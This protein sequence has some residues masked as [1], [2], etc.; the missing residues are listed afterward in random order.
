[1]IYGA[2]TPGKI[3]PAILFPAHLLPDSDMSKTMIP[4]GLS[5]IRNKN[6]MSVTPWSP[7]NY[8]LD[9]N[10]EL[11]LETDMK[12]GHDSQTQ[13]EIVEAMEN[14]MEH[15]KGK[16]KKKKKSGKKSATKESEDDQEDNTGGII[17]EKGD[18]LDIKLKNTN[19][20][21]KNVPCDKRPNFSESS[22]KDVRKERDS[23]Y[24]KGNQLLKDRN[25]IQSNYKSLKDT[26]DGKLTQEQC[27]AQKSG[28][29]SGSESSSSSS[30]SAPVVTSSKTNDSAT[31]TTKVGGEGEMAKKKGGKKKKTSVSGIIFLVFF[32]LV[33]IAGMGA[34][35]YAYSNQTLTSIPVII[36]V[37]ISYIFHLITAI[38]FS[39][40]NVGTGRAGVILS[41]AGIA[42][43]IASVAILGS[44][45]KTMGVGAG[46]LIFL[47]G[48]ILI[49]VGLSKA[50]RKKDEKTLRD[51]HKAS[52]VSP[53][54]G[55]ICVIAILYNVF[56]E[57]E[58]RNNSYNN[59]NS[60]NNSNRN[61]NNSNN[62]SN[63]LVNNA[64]RLLR[65][66]G[67]ALQEEKPSV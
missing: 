2:P 60:N 46:A 11:H 59:N 10:G 19:M 38:Y 54:M 64:E 3:S 6:I 66:A 14:Y 62:V 31:S 67:K 41:G 36:L 27:N 26:C 29:G 63:R 18:K 56:I 40:K 45:L 55:I 50:N 24:N 43:A 57:G 8:N 5:L 49:F 1:M 13:V 4:N 58:V 37:G 15:K 48:M 12:G 52:Y 23:L 7:A 25:K 22:F 47:I 65:E 51:L 34:T 30:S 42:G 32:F 33:L 53:I 20:K 21:R 17:P 44:G 35:G 61:N 16:K 9:G 39:K 28:S